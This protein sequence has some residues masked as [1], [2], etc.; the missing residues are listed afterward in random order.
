MQGS[1]AWALVCTLYLFLVY[2]W[3]YTVQ[4]FM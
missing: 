4:R 3:R 2:K 1:A